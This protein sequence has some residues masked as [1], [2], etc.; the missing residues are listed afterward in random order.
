MPI[1]VGPKPS[2][3]DPPTADIVSSPSTNTATL[4]A[5]FSKLPRELR[6]MI[7]HELWK[8]TPRIEVFGPPPLASGI[9]VRKRHAMYYDD[10]KHG[11]TD[12]WDHSHQTLPSWLRVNTQTLGEGMEQFRSKGVWCINDPWD[13]EFI[14]VANLERKSPLMHPKFARTV[15]LYNMP[16]EVDD[17]I[18]TIQHLARMFPRTTALKELQ[19]R[20]DIELVAFFTQ[21]DIIQA[22][23]GGSR[24]YEYSGVD[25]FS[26][27]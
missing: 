13:P 27:F 2:D 3:G 6:D 26:G 5:G 7:Y 12:V 25:D 8:L 9:K 15:R 20:C 17:R 4:P 18:T 14:R 16:E 24:V 11:S 21:E 22:L 1:Q 23:S 10:D 19:V